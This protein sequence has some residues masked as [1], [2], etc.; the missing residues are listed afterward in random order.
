MKQTIL[1]VIVAAINSNGESDF[2]FFKM[3]GLESVFETEDGIHLAE[4]KRFSES[5]GYE[6]FLVYD[7]Y[8]SAGNNILDKF[9]WKTA[10]TIYLDSK[11]IWIE[12][13]AS[14]QVPDPK[15]DD[16]HQH[17]F[18]GTVTGFRNGNFIVEDMDG[19]S[20]EIEPYRLTVESGSD[21]IFTKP[22]R[23]EDS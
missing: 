23:N 13:S 17:A 3:S 11:G 4:A 9:E 6:A 1:K 15:S 12:D 16:I 20:F 21:E 2:H 7:E 14:V 10:S 5:E 18:T 22:I 19:D 8:D